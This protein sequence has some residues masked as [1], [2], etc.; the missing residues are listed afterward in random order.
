MTFTPGVLGQAVHFDPGYAIGEFNDTID[1]VDSTKW[2]ANVEFI[3]GFSIMAWIRPINTSAHILS[4]TS[5]LGDT[6]R[7]G[8]GFRWR[9]VNEGSGYGGLRAGIADNTFVGGI[10]AS[11][12]P[13]LVPDGEWTHVAVTYDGSLSGGF[14]FFVNGIEVSTTVE[15][16]PG[17][18]NGLVTTGPIPFRI[19]AHLADSGGGIG[20][21]NGD[22][23]HLS[24]WKG[25]LSSEAVLNDF[26]YTTEPSILIQNLIEDMQILNLHKGSRKSLEAKLNT[27]LRVLG[28]TN[29]ANDVAATNALNAFINAVEAQQGKKIPHND[30]IMLISTAQEIIERLAHVGK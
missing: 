9:G 25:A 17:G 10:T 11:T 1:F 19:G 6:S 18:Y 23:D 14:R 15:V 27:A 28:D 21:M 5:T 7:R 29:P 26:L 24:I 2:V 8:F 30:A 20:S 12:A 13:G 16:N 22:I 4:H 3:E